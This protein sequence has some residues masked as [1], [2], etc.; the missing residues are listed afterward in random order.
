[1]QVKRQL[2][3]ALVLLLF[4]LVAYTLI[5]FTLDIPTVEA[6]TGLAVEQPPAPEAMQGSSPVP[7]SPYSP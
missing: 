3:Y 4:A 1:M 6:D 7:V 2:N 5:G